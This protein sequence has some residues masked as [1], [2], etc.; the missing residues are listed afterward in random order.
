V[1]FAVLTATPWRFEYAD[2]TAQL[3]ASQPLISLTPGGRITAVRLNNRSLQPLRLPYGQAES[4]YAAYRAWA[5]LVGRPE[6]RLT[7]RLA[8]GDC[9]IFDNT[10]ILHARTAF[11][12][13]DGALPG[14][15]RPDDGAGERHLQGCYADIDGLLSALA[16]LRRPDPAR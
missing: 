7:L 15:A 3:S 5:A 16:V 13:P 9:L 14:E 11:A 10:R 4:A 1:S 2:E 12:V 8:P 6:F